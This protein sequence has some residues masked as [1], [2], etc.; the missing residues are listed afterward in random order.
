MRFKALGHIH[1]RVYMGFC[2][3]LSL[4]VY[5]YTWAEGKPLNPNTERFLE[6]SEAQ[7]AW[8]YMGTFTALGH[9]VSQSDKNQG[10]C[11]YNWYFHDS[12]NRRKEIEAALRLYPE[13]V[14]S[15]VIL[16]LLYKHCG[17]FRVLGGT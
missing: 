9:L 17:K 3:I 15:S 5:Q 14:P 8:W 16:G 12:E 2:L 11:I 1:S 13:Y 4:A 7:R 6:N 10:D